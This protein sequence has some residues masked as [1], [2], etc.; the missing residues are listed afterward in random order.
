MNLVGHVLASLKVS[1]QLFLVRLLVDDVNYVNLLLQQD[2][3]IKTSL[4][5]IPNVSC[6]SLKNKHGT[7]FHV[8]QG[9]DV[10]PALEGFPCQVPAKF[11][12]VLKLNLIKPATDCDSDLVDGCF[13]DANTNVWIPRAC[14]K[15]YVCA[16]IYEPMLLA[17]PCVHWYGYESFIDECTHFVLKQS[18]KQT[19]MK[20]IGSQ[21]CALVHLPASKKHEPSIYDCLSGNKCPCIE[22]ISK[23]HTKDLYFIDR[24]S[25]ALNDHERV[26][27]ALPD[28]C[29]ES[30][31]WMHEK[32]LLSNGL[33]TC[34][35]YDVLLSFDFCILGRLDLSSKM[36]F[37]GVSSMTMGNR[38]SDD[39]F[40]ERVYG[41]A[42]WYDQSGADPSKKCLYLIDQAQRIDIVPFY[43]YNYYGEK[44]RIDDLPTL[45]LNKPVHAVVYIERVA[46][47]RTMDNQMILQAIP[48][49][50]HVHV[51]YAWTRSP[52]NLEVPKAV[53]YLDELAEKGSVVKTRAVILK[54]LFDSQPWRRVYKIGDGK[55]LVKL[56]SE[57]G[58]SLR[59]GQWYTLSCTVLQNGNLLLLKQDPV[60]FTHCQN[61]LRILL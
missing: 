40:I 56:V 53:L 61:L 14:S 49:Q 11:K 5:F 37:E 3:A 7:K 13:Y 55:R 27:V 4:V 10:V 52:R 33:L 26:P 28:I 8:F 50:T 35:R 43:Y 36:L 21:A 20:T 42:G 6:K 57:H 16:H 59:V 58:D 47:R 46:L 23:W 32:I 22:I 41:V 48:R 12:H 25:M 44:K 1:S 45:S 34:S 19:L 17:F 30:V 29:T 31:I 15:T 2:A 38:S 24:H 18:V 51:E 39:Q 9:K 60:P 54:I